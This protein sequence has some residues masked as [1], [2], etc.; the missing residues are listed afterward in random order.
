[1]GK[2]LARFDVVIPTWNLS[3]TT[4]ACLR[5]LS[6]T[7]GAEHLRVIWVDNGSDDFHRLEV[8]RY[9]VH[10]RE[11]ARFDYAPILLR[12]NLGFVKATNVGIAASS[13]PFVALMNNDVEVPEDWLE[14]FCAT[15]EERS[16]GMVGPLTDNPL[17]WQGQ[18]H[19]RR[20]PPN[21]GRDGYRTLAWDGAMLAFFCVAIRREVIL[22]V[23][24]LS[25]RFGVGL[26]DDDDYCA[27]ARAR[28][29]NIALRTDLVVHHAH[30]TTF[31]AL[32]S[33]GEI[34]EMELGA[35]EKLKGGRK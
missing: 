5:S 23:G 6:R 2:E 35:I 22:D 33:P 24:Y 14:K 32:Y 26:G 7:R 15:M 11:S 16:I 13:A 3:A 21:P 9:L 19:A 8:E 4:L 20:M 12:E 1:M 27:R 34:A 31:R 30:R 18:A 17:Q 29:W 28:G 25:E 10:L